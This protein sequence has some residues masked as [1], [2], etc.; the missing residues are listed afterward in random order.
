MIGPVIRLCGTK[1]TARKSRQRTSID[2]SERAV[3]IIG[4]VHG[5]LKELLALE[6]TI[7]DDAASLPAKKLIIMLGDYVD[8]G[9]ASA[10]VIDHLIDVCPEGFERLCLTG[11]HDMAM[12]EY[13]DGRLALSTWLQ[14]GGDA[15]LLSYGIDVEH[16]KQIYKSQAKL[17]EIIRRAVPVRHAEFLRTLPILITAGKF[18]FVHAG[19]RPSIP[20][21]E[22]K[23]EDLVFIRS[24]FFNN[25][26]LLKHWVIHGHT[27]IDKPVRDGKRFNLDTGAFYTGK[28]S[29]LRLWNH[30]GRIFTT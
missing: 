30:R 12:L 18:L 28:L 24:E 5:C 27:P 2:I 3:Y 29:A 26:H 8:R 1:L 4:D 10:Q 25:S 15:T 14:M 7:S 22:Q 17:D 23:D 9:P 11:N 16:L 21:Q 20:I 19:I 13:L 6:R